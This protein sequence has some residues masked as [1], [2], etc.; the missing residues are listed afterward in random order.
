MP[1]TLRLSVTRR[2]FTGVVAL[3][4]TRI[5]SRNDFAAPRV[6]HGPATA[7]S[8]TGY[9]NATFLLSA[10]DF[11]E[12]VAENDAHF[13]A[14]MPRSSFD[15]MHIPDSLRFDW[16][17]FDLKDTSS[18]EVVE[19]WARDI[20]QMMALAGLDVDRPVALYDDGTM[21]AAR[22]WWILELLGNN[23][24]SVLN[25]GIAAWN[26]DQMPVESGMPGE[27]P[28]SVLPKETTS[29]QWDA[30]ATLPEVA[31]LVGDPDS[32]FLDVRD[33]REYRDGH[34]P[35]AINLPYTLNAVDGEPGQWKSQD[36]LMQMYTGAGV[37]VGKQIIPYCS[38]GVR[39]AVTWF[40]LR[41]LGYAN[42]RLFT[43]SWREWSRYPEL[44]V[45]TGDTP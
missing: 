3:A 40:T 12:W 18:R 5:A 37:F 8:D 10:G 20:A 32:I 21:F 44:P 16:P 31:D 43:G 28:A 6:Q 36:A 19:A 4:G 25:G 7:V 29:V 2:H 39:S 23:R 15:T 11:H 33:E 30:I 45:T 1:R 24:K 13:V 26:R 14:L 35:G 27:A 22:L 38:S 34:I 17:D 41:V 42:V 9:A